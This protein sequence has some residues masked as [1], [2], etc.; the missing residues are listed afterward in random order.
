MQG[1][2]RLGAVLLEQLL[3]HE[4]LPEPEPGRGRTVDLPDAIDEQQPPETTLA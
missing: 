3:G 2:T 1:T 4:Q